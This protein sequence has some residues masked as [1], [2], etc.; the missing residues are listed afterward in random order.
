M[1]ARRL[2]EADEAVGKN[3]FDGRD[4]DGDAV[5]LVTFVNEDPRETG[6]RLTLKMPFHAKQE[7]EERCV[8][9]PGE[10]ESGSQ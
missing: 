6:P 5:V 10:V 1:D 4:T 7:E 8:L 9:G 2:C 3:L